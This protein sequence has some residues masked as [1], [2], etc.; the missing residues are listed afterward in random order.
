MKIKTKKLPYEKAIS[1]PRE[2][3][4]KPIKPSIFFRTLIRLVSIFDLMAT[5]F[6]F[7]KKNMEKAGDGS[8][9]ILMNHS[10]F[11]DLEIAHRIMYPKPMCIVCTS[12]AFVGMDF[13]MRLIGCIPT[14]KFV[15]DMTL[16]RDIIYTIKNKKTSILMYPEA[17]Y[18][19]DGTATPLPKSLGMLV[20]KLGVPVVNIHTYGAFSR[21]PLYNCL[22]K[23]KVKVSA[24]VECLLSSDEIAEKSADEIQSILDKAFDFDNFKWQREN[25]V[26]I[27]EKDRAVGLERILYKCA[28]CETEGEM[29][30]E[31]DSIVCKKCGASYR[32]TELGSLEGS[33]NPRFDHIPDWYAWERECVKNEL[34]SGEYRLDTEVDIG[35]MVNHSAIYMVG[36]GRLIHDNSGFKLSGCDGKLNYEQKPLSS[37]GLYADYYWYEI[38][39]IIC[40]G[41]KDCLYYCFPKKP[42]VVSK[43][44]LAAE[45]L[46][47]IYKEKQTQRNKE[48]NK[49]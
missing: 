47:K 29:I 26:V 16:I 21:Q 24:E 39:D 17:S 1:L 30:G 27:D 14:Q 41:D 22:K 7:T 35:M 33:G 31:G 12:D 43:T 36:E 40:I 3:H 6:T 32:L 4:K 38:G 18:S 48:E 23:R 10:S 19:F 49:K 44:R 45:E 46:Y 15:T 8:Y 28:H 9:L 25:S 34:L 20:K 5:K 11:I 13:L 2:K 42:G 37:Y